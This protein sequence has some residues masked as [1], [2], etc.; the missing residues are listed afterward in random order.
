[1]ERSC[2]FP[3][4]AGGETEADREE[5]TGDSD[6]PFRALLKKAFWPPAPIGLCWEGLGVKA[7][8]PRLQPP[9]LG[10][11]LLAGSLGAPLAER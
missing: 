6:F 10:P 5:V 4:F 3:H 1:M 11:L 2:A 8:T 9:F 7:A